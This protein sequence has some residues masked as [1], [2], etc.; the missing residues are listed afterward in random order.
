MPLDNSPYPAFTG[1]LL[2]RLHD[3]RRSINLVAPHGDRRRQV[4]DELCR[5]AP[6][7]IKIVRINCRDHR[8]NYSG[9]IKAIWCR[10][11]SNKPQ[12][13]PKDLAKLMGV[14]ENAGVVWLLLEEFDNLL[15]VPEANRDKQYNCQFFNNH[16]NSLKN[17]PD[18]RLLTVTGRPHREYVF[19]CEGQNT[20]PLDLEIEILPPLGN[21]YPGNR[22]VNGVS[23]L[24]NWGNANRMMRWLTLRLTIVRNWTIELLKVMIPLQKVFL[25]LQN[26][27]HNTFKSDDGK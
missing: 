6:T 25:K 5:L 1:K 18:L 9:L 2:R 12:N 20:S 8:K 14:L 21:G 3:E 7:E 11:G 19:V 15:E 4:I 27:H 22:F 24:F 16:L 10:L 23:R 13:P 17:L 26:W